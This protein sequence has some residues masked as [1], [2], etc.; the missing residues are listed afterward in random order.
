[1]A[2]VDVFEGTESEQPLFTAEFD[3]LP[4]VGEHI[5][6]EAGGYFQYYNIVELWH[7]EDSE[8]GKYCACLRVAIED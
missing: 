7:R 3:F 8:R 6:R 1:M 4:R 2:L 5:A